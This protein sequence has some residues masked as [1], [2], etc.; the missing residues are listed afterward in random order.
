MNPERNPV[1]AVVVFATALLCL[2]VLALLHARYDAIPITETPKA[3]APATPPADNPDN[4][5]DNVSS[6][7][8]QTTRAFKGVADQWEV[9]FNKMLPELY[10]QRATIH[11]LRRELA[12]CRN[13]P[14]KRKETVK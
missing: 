4:D 12:E 6:D 8:L 11:K 13:S 14:G 1:G 3:A 9:L 5:S 7:V 2:L 10:R